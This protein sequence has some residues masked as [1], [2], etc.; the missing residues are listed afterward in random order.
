MKQYSDLAERWM[1]EYL[2]IDTT[3]PP[4]NE[5]R[6]TAW[7]KKIFDAEGIQNRAF[8]LAPG[9]D[10]LWA[11]VS[12]SSA[13]KKRPIILLNHTDVVTSDPSHWTHPPFSG[14]V[15]NG[16]MYGRGAQDM[17]NEGL[18]ELVVMVMLN[19]EKPPIDR[20]VIFI[21]TPDEEVN[22][23][24]AD[25]VMNGH[26][27]LLEN[28][29]FLINEG[30]ENVEEDGKMRYVGVNVAEKA[31]DWLHLV[32][33]GTPGHGSRPMP[34]SAP[35]RLVRALNR[36]L[37]W[38]QPLSLQPTVEQFLRRMAALQ[39]GER[40]AWFRD[41][42]AAMK[43]PKFR[44]WVRSDRELG[45]MF[46]DTISLTMMG[47]SLQTNVIP[48]DAWANVD[49]RLLPGQDPARFEA[50]LKKVI[51]D[52]SITFEHIGAFHKPNSSSIDTAL[53]RAIEAVS[54]RYFSGGIVL[55]K[56]SSGYN[57]TQRYREV[58]I[59]SYGFCPYSATEAEI[60]TAHANDERIR[61]E[62]LRRGPRVLY[63]VVTVVG[64]D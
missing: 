13:S 62:Q 5:A 58:G 24:G 48:P 42:P 16:V 57:E 34:D 41:P 21:A 49:I 64:S 4:G 23:L 33:H 38:E 6:A 1:Q 30:G 11:K 40:V 52:P 10:L 27:D 31:P 51:N 36:V 59:V 14:E 39:T 55:P 37:A 22:S 60:E 2:R 47:G 44:A 63:D 8:N 15:A 61:V 54:G 43:D 35:N 53:F 9:R 26:T 46:H 17:K 12:A 45:Y 20:D 28:A 56:M 19:R 7:M 50:E 29:E 32:A 3:N 18:A 25:W